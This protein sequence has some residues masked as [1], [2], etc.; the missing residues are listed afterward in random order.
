M[1][2]VVGT[3]GTLQTPLDKT[4]ESEWARINSVSVKSNLAS[5]YRVK[6]RTGLAS[7]EIGVFPI[8]SGGTTITVDYISSMQ[9]LNFAVGT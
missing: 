4:D 2:S 3:S 7:Q 6:N 9:E 8:P 1:A 5:N